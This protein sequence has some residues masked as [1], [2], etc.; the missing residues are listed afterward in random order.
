M[1]FLGLASLSGPVD[2]DTLTFVPPDSRQPVVTAPTDPPAVAAG[3]TETTGAVVATAP[4]TE[5][6]DG[7]AAPVPVPGPG[8]AIDEGAVPPVGPEPIASPP[9]ATSA[10]C[11]DAV[12]LK[13]D[14]SPWVCTFGD[15]FDGAE[16]DR[17]RWLPFQSAYANSDVAGGA[18]IRDHPDNIQVADGALHLTV[19]AEPAGI[20]CPT[21]LGG[22]FTAYYSAAS[23][24][25]FGLFSQTY[26]RYE[27]RARFP[28]TDD[29]PGLHGA[30]WLYP[31]N[32]L[33]YGPW[34]TSGEIDVAEFYSVHSDR[35]IPYIHYAELLPNP[36]VTN[37]YCFVED[38]GE[39]HD[40]AVEWTPTTITTLYDGVPCTT[41]TWTS[42]VPLGPPAPFDHPFIVCLTQ[43]LGSTG[44]RV[45]PATPVPASMVVDHVRVYR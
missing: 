35:A 32:P 25:T 30:L 36:S 16:L 5:G 39:F 26:G 28:D 29:V 7:E 6:G 9:P 19:R 22:S 31:Q 10:P 17:T 2:E 42:L 23:I 11:G 41:T 24:S 18:C 1:A 14:G 8:A 4:G 38:I 37:D 13:A 43:A 15:E 27:F 44:N 33:R 34:P 45:T 3:P 21:A 12:P 40:Y 20:H